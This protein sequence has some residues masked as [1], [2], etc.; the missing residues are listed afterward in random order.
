MDLQQLDPNIDWYSKYYASKGEFKK[1]T[2]YKERGYDLLKVSP[3]SH[4]MRIKRH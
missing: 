3:K 2:D 1:C 4:L